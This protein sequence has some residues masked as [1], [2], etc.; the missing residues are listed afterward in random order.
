[1]SVDIVILSYNRPES[2]RRLLQS[3]I[4]LTDSRLSIHINDDN[5]PQK[6]ELYQLYEDFQDRLS[7]PLY[8]H[9]REKNIGYDK[10]L[11]SSF[12][13]GT[14]SHTFLMS[15]DDYFDSNIVQLFDDILMHDVEVGFVS[16]RYKKI[17]YRSLAM[18]NGIIDK[19]KLIYDSILFSGLIF[20]KSS[21]F[22]LDEFNVF[23]KDC[24]YSQV[25]IAPKLILDGAEF[26]YFNK[27]P[28]LLGNDGEN[29]F[30]TN[31]SADSHQS[32]LIDR[33]SIYSNLNY[34]KRLLKVVRFLSIFNGNDIYKSFHREFVVRLIGYLFKIKNK[35]RIHFLQLIEE[36]DYDLSRR[37]LFFIKASS[38]IPFSITKTIYNF[39]KNNMRKSG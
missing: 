22:P 37:K 13:K 9:H 34:Q 14:G 25:F 11:M 12:E 24:I 19:S 1:M 38:Y 27:Y 26:K 35:E 28:I 20:K 6:D 5:S 10:N 3:M 30:G 2:L 23:L 8:F 18:K 39:A 21:M 7:I 32:D 15:N 29:F 36:N 16:Y 4:P 33:D 31:S 17:D